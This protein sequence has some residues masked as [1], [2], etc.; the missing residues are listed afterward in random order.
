[1]GQLEGRSK[2]PLATVSPTCHPRPSKPLPISTQPPLP[3]VPGLPGKRAQVSPTSAGS[4]QKAPKCIVSPNLSNHH[5]LKDC[6]GMLVSKLVELHSQCHSWEAFI[7]AV[8]GRPHLSKSIKQLQHPAMPLLKYYQD[9]GVPVHME[10]KEWDWEQLEKMIK[11]GPHL[12]AVQ[13]GDFIHGKMAD[14]LESGFWPVLP[15]SL[16]CNLEGLHLSP[17]GCIPQHEQL[18][19][20]IVDHTY[21]NMNQESLPLALPE[22]MQFGRV[23]D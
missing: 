16:V 5:L 4:S 21:S 22:A 12:L 11:C 19:R 2:L 6:I 15:L 3:P 20:L 14:F 7:A 8:H 17:L 1:M 13:H 10:V 9:H 18:P 23:L